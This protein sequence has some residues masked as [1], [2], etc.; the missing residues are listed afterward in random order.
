MKLIRLSVALAATAIMF[1]TTASAQAVGGD[2]AGIPR[3]NLI[4][5]NPIGLLFEWYNGE[6]ERAI[7]NT[8]SIALAASTFDFWDGNERYTTVDAIGRYYPQARALRG[9]SVGASLGFVD[10]SE[11]DLCAGFCED[12]SGT[13]ATLG[14]R[15]DY[16]WIIGRDQSFA[17]A[18]G[19]GAKR[20]LADNVGTEFI[21]IGRLSIGYAW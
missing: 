10:V 21:P 11:P 13:S 20:V 2:R 6:Y 4:S 14:V 17:V 16:V 5:A 12:D 7:S 15:G 8:T 9:F 3:Q 18:T 1:A 19:I